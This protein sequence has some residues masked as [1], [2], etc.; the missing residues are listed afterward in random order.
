MNK[1]D[2]LK[3][4]QDCCPEVDFENETA[5][6]TGKVIDSVDLVTMISALEDSFGISIDM[7]ELE[8][9]QFDSLE[10]IQQLVERSQ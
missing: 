10:S 4:L 5:L 7:S 6:I 1:K 9:E 2:L 8:P 3:V